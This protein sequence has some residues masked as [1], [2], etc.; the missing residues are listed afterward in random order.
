MSLFKRPIWKFR[1]VRIITYLIAFWLLLALITSLVLPRYIKNIAVQQISEQTGRKADIDKVGFNLLSFTVYVHN[2]TLYDTDKVT[3]QFSAKEMIAS[4]SLSSLFHLAP[5]LDRIALIDPKVHIVRLSDKEAGTY[6]FS[7]ILDRFKKPDNT[8]PED[9]ANK[10]PFYFALN[11]VSIAN[12]QVSLEDKV[13]GKSIDIQKL[14]VL[15]PHFSTFPSKNP[16]TLAPSL[17]AD[18]NGTPLKVTAE[19]PYNSDTLPS[20]ATIHLDHLDI[21]QYLPFIPAKLPVDIQS[22]EISSDLAL[23]FSPSTDDPSLVLNGTVQLDK[24]N[25]QDNHHQPLLKTNQAKV[26]LTNLDALKLSGEITQ[27]TVDQ[28]EVWATMAKNGQINWVETFA[29]DDDKDKPKT[30]TNFNVKQLNVNNGAV[31]WTDAAYA[32]PA[33]KTTLSQIQVNAKNIATSDKAPAGSFIASAVENKQGNLFIRG[34]L[35]PTTLDLNSQLELR[36]INLANYT[37]YI[38]AYLDAQFNGILSAN[39]TVSMVKG[40]AKVSDIATTIGQFNLKPRHGGGITAT[41]LALVNGNLDLQQHHMNIGAIHLNEVNTQLIR[42]KQGQINLLPEQHAKSETKA[43]TPTKKTANTSSSSPW[44]VTLNKLTIDRSNLVYTDE[45]MKQPQPLSLQNITLNA[46]GISSALDRPATLQFNSAINQSGHLNVSA[47]TSAQLNETNVDIDLKSLSVL[48]FQ[49]FIPDSIKIAVTNGDISTKG[50]LVI[51]H[52][53][54]SQHRS[55]QYKGNAVLEKFNVLDD[56]TQIPFLRFVALNLNDIDTRFDA[57]RPLIAVNKVSLSNFYARAVL[58]EKG[59]LNI[60]QLVSSESDKEK[61]N[62]A[63]NNK[64]NSKA[65]EKT[66]KTAKTSA[67]DD[68][69]PII[70]IG[71]VNLDKGQIN[72][73]DNFVKPNYHVNL[74]GLTGTIGAVDSTKPEPAPVDLH[75]KIDNDSPV[76]I[77]GSINPL[78]SPLFLDIKAT[79]TGVELPQLTPYSSKYAGY[80]IEKGKLSA[81]VNYKIQDQHLVASNNVKID[82]L[83]FGD[84]VDGPNATKLPVM[85]AVSLLKDR[86]GVIDLDVPISGSLEDPQFSIGG[87]ILRAFVNLIVKAVTSPFSLISSMF[88]GGEELSHLEF[89]SGSSD[90]TPDLIKKLDS[91]NYALSERPGLS[92]DIMGKSDINTD[93]TGLVNLQ[94]IQQMKMLKWQDNG[95]K[96]SPADIKLS[97]EDEQKYLTVLYKKASFKKPSNFIG[98]SKSEPVDEMKRLFV[99]NAVVSEQDLRNLANERATNIKNYIET[100]GNIP[101]ER[102]F[103]IAPKVVTNTVQEK[104]PNMGVDFSLK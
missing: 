45:G 1:S 68:H 51:Q 81:T 65:A 34:S 61:D 17:S 42:D 104:E 54:N 27:L 92:L 94:L 96:G 41:T 39:A 98:F 19:Q 82:Q 35:Q 8:T 78:F 40:Q 56:T 31:H 15:L 77:N 47:N 71:D 66:T 26:T 58:T 64:A 84:H 22:A 57:N 43:I 11:N 91:L 23:T 53:L 16:I 6:N 38:G 4:A 62:E 3:P 93:K 28:P 95:K 72:F 13:T 90:V 100:Q 88:G 29:S 46:Q 69:S 70:R 97:S 63:D 85:L 76:L 67:K 49:S 99:E 101:N 20:K 73:T 5:V 12:G 80:P 25:V 37:P 87:V 36:S 44:K 60:S 9:N 30:I 14:N 50:K 24:V 74:T 102:V 103:I 2:F 55:I 86:N 59:K 33:I 79:A 21:T 89:A 83:T 7:D 48:P 75:A 32:H 18:V 10:K 52:L